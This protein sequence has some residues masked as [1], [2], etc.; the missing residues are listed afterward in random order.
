AVVDAEVEREAEREHERDEL[1]RPPA[2]DRERQQERRERR[3]EAR[4]DAAGQRVR[5]T[6]C[7]NARAAYFAPAIVSA[8][9]NAHC[10]ATP[11]IESVCDS[12][13]SGATVESASSSI[14]RSCVGRSWA[15]TRSAS[16]GSCRKP[17]L[18]PVAAI[19]CSE[20]FGD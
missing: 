15:A 17:R 7:A 11:A 19:T 9:G 1:E 16:S 20:P 6:C 13:V 14:Q 18:K 8:A 12:S 2:V 10:P 4:L 3:D 5:H